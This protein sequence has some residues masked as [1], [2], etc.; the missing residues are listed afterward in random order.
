VDSGG[1]GDGGKEESRGNT[2]GPGRRI[3]TAYTLGW[4]WMD[5]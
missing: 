5:L 1:R 2:M 4:V 3:C